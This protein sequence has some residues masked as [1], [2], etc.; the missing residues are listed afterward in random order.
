MASSHLAA[1]GQTSMNFKLVYTMRTDPLV[2]KMYP[3]KPERYVAAPSTDRPNANLSFPFFLVSEQ[4]RLFV[5]KRK[6]GMNSV[7]PM[8]PYN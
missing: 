3:S 5:W 8:L 7:Q 1:P 2:S 6:I 4:A